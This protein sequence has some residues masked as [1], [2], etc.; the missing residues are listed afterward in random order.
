MDFILEKQ[1]YGHEEIERLEKLAVDIFMDPA[2]T[3]KEKIMQEHQVKTVL[4]RIQSR[5]LEIICAYDDK[6]GQRR[7]EMDMISGASELSEFYRS[8][9]EIKDFHRRN[10]NELAD[11]FELEVKDVKRMRVKDIETMFTGEESFGKYLDMNMHHLVFNNFKDVKKV[12]YVQYLDSFH[13]LNGLPKGADYV[14]YVNDLSDYIE[15]FFKKSK[16]LINFEQIKNSGLEEFEKYYQNETSKDLFCL[17]CSKLFS[18]NSVFDSHLNGK[19][20]KKAQAELDA[21]KLSIEEKEETLNRLYNEEIQKEKDFAAKEFLLPFYAK[22]LHEVIEDTK[23]F[24]ERKQSRTFEEREMDMEEEEEVIEEEQEVEEEEDVKL[25]NPKGLPL[26]WDGKPIPYWLYK[27]HGLGFQFP[28]EICGNYIYMGRRAF[29]RHFSEWRHTYALKCLGITNS[30]HF[31]EI[32]KIE[33]ALACNIWEKLKKQSKEENFV[34]EDMEE[35]ED[36]SGNVYNKKTYEDLQRQGI[37]VIGCYIDPLKPHIHSNMKSIFF[38][39]VSLSS[40]LLAAPSVLDIDGKCRCK[41]KTM[42]ETMSQTKTIMQ[43]STVTETLAPITESRTETT[44]LTETSTLPRET[45]TITET[46]E[47]RTN[48]IT[49]TQTLSP[50]TTTLQCETVTKTETLPPMTVT[51]TCPPR[52]RRKCR[53]CEKGGYGDDESDDQDGDDY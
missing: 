10:P 2:K 22:E 1:R 16:P 27:L 20:H 11:V 44:T 18:K 50:I 26:G 53:K 25:H 5:S 19:K 48:T 9:K 32:V 8:L 31:Y 30:K 40:Y 4:E 14:K 35:F 7:Q 38:T 29:E 47:T 21:K 3:Y 37:F 51:P 17:A 41:R 42:T 12:D 36:E 39:I 45:N 23:A 24:I 34:A 43:T 33:E 46:C 15:E 13:I 28:C 49:E 6:D 52:R